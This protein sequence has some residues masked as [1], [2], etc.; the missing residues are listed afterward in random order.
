MGIR[1]LFF[2]AIAAWLCCAT[3]FAQ[4]SDTIMVKRNG[5][6]FKEIIISKGQTLYSLSKTLGISQ[7]TLI[8]YNAGLN[9]GMKSGM[10][11][12]IPVPISKPVSQKINNDAA[13]KHKVKS[14]ET[15]FGIARM[16]GLSQDE[17]LAQNPELKAGLKTGMLLAINPKP[18][19]NIPGEENRINV[20]SSDKS[21][22]TKLSACQI[23]ET[24]VREKIKVSL[25]LPLYSSK[26][27]NQIKSRTGLEFY[28]GCMLALDSLKKLGISIDLHVFDTQSDSLAM[29][30]IL[31]SAELASS[32][33]ILGPLH[34]SEFRQISNVIAGKKTMTIAPLASSSALISGAP[35]AVKLIP[36][37]KR[38]ME[39]LVDQVVKNYK[40]ARYIVVRNANV[41]D[42]DNIAYITSALA[43]RIDTS[44][45]SYL[46]VDYSGVNDILEKLDSD[47]ENILFFPSTAQVQVIDAI[48]RLNASR[49]GKRITLV[50]LNEWNSFENIE[51]EHL[52]NLN[53]T[54]ATPWYIDFNSPAAK[55]FRK[56]FRDEYK[57]EPG[58]YAFQGFDAMLY[59]VKATARINEI[60]SECLLSVP[61]ENGFCS[62]F[63]FTKENANSGVDNNHVFVLQLS[64]YLAAPINKP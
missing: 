7:D 61:S 20:D 13:L 23:S 32:D 57:G 4:A 54:Y 53:F 38:L 59:F 11:V 22:L 46:N 29:N 51:Y 37:Q 17:L 33:F 3:A 40:N 12:L 19:K 50:G 44:N 35:H 2:T 8:A 58:V 62:D 60:S 47:K 9:S 15:I 63:K 49:T 25:V 64:D 41:K 36:D 26:G 10:K 52:N 16:Y 6:D 30:R 39:G 21:A 43:S 5:R 48:A 55:N 56:S 14:G 18:E 42:K 1:N 28:A 24:F 34:A 31:K 27:E 45:S